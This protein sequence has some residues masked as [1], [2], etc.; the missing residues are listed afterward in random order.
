MAVNGVT[1][2]VVQQPPEA[3]L[4]VADD[5][6]TMLDAVAMALSRQRFQAQETVRADRIRVHAAGGLAA[7]TTRKRGTDGHFG[8][9]A[10]V[11]SA[12]KGRTR[13]QSLGMDRLPTADATAVFEERCRRPQRRVRT[14]LA[15]L[16]SLLVMPATYSTMRSLLLPERTPSRLAL[17][18]G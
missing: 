7:A 15:N 2:P 6:R 13:M 14:L 18:P 17:V 16:E 5:S 3:C 12:V 10:I 1:L 9:P 8:S 11:E 4:L